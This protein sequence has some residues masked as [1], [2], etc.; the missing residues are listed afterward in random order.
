MI[1]SKLTADFRICQQKIRKDGKAMLTGKQLKQKLD[2]RFPETKEDWNLDVS[3]LY[4]EKVYDVMVFD[5]KIKLNT[6]TPLEENPETGMVKVPI[7][8]RIN[9]DENTIKEW[10]E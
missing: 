5:H 8:G 7:L 4:D 3:A 2:L 9:I 6:T 10:E 1:L